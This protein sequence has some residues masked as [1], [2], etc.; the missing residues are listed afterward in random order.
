MKLHEFFEKF[1]NTP[2]DKRF[3]ILTFDVTSPIQDMSL[4]QI[5]E[6]LE[7]LEVEIRSKRTR[8]EEILR[9]VSGFL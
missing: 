1:A 4:L 3:Q 9:V 8:Q 5:Y 2:I 7:L 6:S